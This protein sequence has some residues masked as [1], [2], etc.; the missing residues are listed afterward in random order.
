[1]QV[2]QTDRE[3]RPPLCLDE[4]VQRCLGRIEL[5][6]R[7]LAKFQQRFGVELELLERELRADNVDEVARVAHRLKGTSANV[8]APGLLAVA[9]DIEEQARG[10][11]VA[12]IPASLEQLRREWDRFVGELP[13][14]ELRSEACCRE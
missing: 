6:E 10:R 11:Q 7:V 12:Q 8:G 5:V 4:L 13:A 2:S 3:P 9:A 1:M 14:V